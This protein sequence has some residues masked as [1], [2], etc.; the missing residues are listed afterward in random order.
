MSDIRVLS[1]GVVSPDNESVNVSN[2]TAELG[3][4][5]GKST[6]VILGTVSGKIKGFIPN[7]S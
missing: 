7:E 6:I 1:G 2:F 4:K 3:G 5:L